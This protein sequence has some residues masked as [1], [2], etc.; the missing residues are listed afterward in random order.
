M[1]NTK[2]INE[3]YARPIMTINLCYRLAYGTK[4]RLFLCTGDLSFSCQYTELSEPANHLLKT[5]IY[6]VLK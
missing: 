3:I 1:L 4:L 6:K 5:S 2:L